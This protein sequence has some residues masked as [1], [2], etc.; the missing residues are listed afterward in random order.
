[1]YNYLMLEC[2]E[3]QND[4]FDRRNGNKVAVPKQVQ[5]LQKLVS[6]SGLQPKH[7]RSSSIQQADAASQ[8][9]AT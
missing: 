3:R 4:I 1:M 8:P 7:Q 2:E 9:H 5:M 6:C